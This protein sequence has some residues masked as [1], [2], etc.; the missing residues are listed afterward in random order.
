VSS[1][2]PE[3]IQLFPPEERHG[4]H[5]TALVCEAKAPSHV[6]LSRDR[7]GDA[8][9]QQS[10]VSVAR[11][12][13]TEKL[14][15][16][17][18]RTAAFAEYRHLAALLLQVNPDRRGLT[19]VITSAVPGEGKTLS[20]ANLALTLTEAYARRVL[21]VEADMRRPVLSEQFGI[22]A[23]LGFCDCLRAGR[24][25]SAATVGIHGGLTILPAGQPNADPVSVLSS[26]R[27]RAFVED[28]ARVFD[29][30][31]FDTPP[32]V[33]L[34][35]AE[36]ISKV[37]DT[38]LLVVHAGRTS[39]QKVQR[40]ADTIGRERIAGVLLNQVQPDTV[41]GKEYDDYYTPYVESTKV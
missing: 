35:D 40:A 3:A 36:L 14:I 22:T 20:A 18:A 7:R 30:V 39:Y 27:L 26:D 21:L 29:C 11:H 8:G 23:V 17:N 25:L 15:T 31:L 4:E 16:N 6:R 19:M 5:V 10:A 37:V 9:V 1:P 24:L 2:A 32:A 12:K 13:A 34:P 41:T 33:L 28:A 38:T